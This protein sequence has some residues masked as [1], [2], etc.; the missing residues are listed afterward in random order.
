MAKAKRKTRKTPKSKVSG[1]HPKA[2]TVDEAEMMFNLWYEI[3][4]TR[5]HQGV[6]DHFGRAVSTIFRV[7]K[8]NDWDKRVKKREKELRNQTDKRAVKKQLDKLKMMEQLERATYASLFVEGKDK[9]GNKTFKLST[10][11]TPAQFIAVAE[12][13]DKVR[14]RYGPS[15]DAEVT[16]LSKEQVEKAFKIL[17]GLTPKALQA[18]GEQIV[19]QNDS[20]E[21]TAKETT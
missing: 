8:A 5:G 10:L 7:A 2:V 14:E 11:P 9:H 13:A 1:Q 15:S 6:A 16:V 18:L 19:K 3:K 4:E 20:Q 12:Y 21:A 17:E